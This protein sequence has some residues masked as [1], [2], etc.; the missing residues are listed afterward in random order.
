M[1]RLVR[2]VAP[3]QHRA[4]APILLPLALLAAAA[5]PQPPPNP[6]PAPQPTYVVRHFDTP[7][8][9]KD[10]DLTA[11]GAARAV[12]LAQWFRGKRLCAILV[13]QYQRTRQTVAPLAA[14]RGIA[15]QT[16]DPANPADAVAR[17][18]ASP[19]PVLIVGHSN[20]VPDLVERL[21]G[22]RPAPLAHGDFGD[23]WTVTAGRTDRTG[24]APEAPSPTP[25]QPR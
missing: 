13:T 21:G 7:A 22:T 24:I 5:A 10:P 15:I 20:T 23:L 19:C 18:T 25:M 11:Q 9:E 4:M 14:S 6:Q 1:I 12:A 2:A 8:G 16:Y 17:A 3:G